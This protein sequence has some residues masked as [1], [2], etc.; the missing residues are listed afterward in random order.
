LPVPNV[1]NETAIFS[2]VSIIVE[3]RRGWRIVRWRRRAWTGWWRWR[4]LCIT[5][6]LAAFSTVSYWGTTIAPLTAAH[7]I[8]T[9]IIRST[10][11]ILSRTAGR[12]RRRWRWYDFC[13]RRCSCC[14]C[15]CGSGCSSLC[16]CLRRSIRWRGWRRSAAS[17]ITRNPDFGTI[18]KLIREEGENRRNV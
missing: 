17:T 3:P 14:S 18:P 8:G 10:R 1:C 4:R 6:A 16:S 5:I 13:R 7:A 9:W 11:I 2:V 15:S 12:S